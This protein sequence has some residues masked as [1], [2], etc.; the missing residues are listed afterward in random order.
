MIFTNFDVTAPTLLE[1]IFCLYMV[2]TI[3][4]L[5]AVKQHYLQQYF[6]AL[7]S[8]HL[9]LLVPACRDETGRWVLPLQSRAERLQGRKGESDTRPRMSLHQLPRIRQ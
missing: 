8:H 2:P 1:N 5:F 7:A 9:P 4:S 3:N 6:H